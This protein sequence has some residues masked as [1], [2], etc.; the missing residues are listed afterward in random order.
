LLFIQKSRKIFKLRFKMLVK[1]LEVWLD[2][3]F[4]RNDGRP[5]RVWREKLCAP[6]CLWVQIMLF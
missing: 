4:R 6:P 5:Q 3:G 1:L 2:S